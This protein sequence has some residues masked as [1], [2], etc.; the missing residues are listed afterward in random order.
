[1]RL[2]L[3]CISIFIF[4]LFATAQAKRNM[5]F[6][7]CI[8][9]TQDDGYALTGKTFTSDAS[10]ED[11]YI[12]KLDDK[13]NIKWTKS[14][15]GTNDQFGNSIIQTKSGGYAVTGATN[16]SGPTGEDVYIVD[17]DAL[18]NIKCT[19]SIGGFND[20]VGYTIYQ[21]DDGSFVVTGATTPLGEEDENIYVVK[22]DSACKVKS[23]KVIP[24]LK[25]SH[26]SSIIPTSDGGYAIGGYKEAPPTEHQA[27]DHF[28]FS[29]V[30][31]DSTGNVQW[32]KT[33]GGCRKQITLFHGANQ[34]R[35]LCGNRNNR[36]RICR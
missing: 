30:K 24:G 14:A 10:G 22:I 5:G 15:G 16:S 6:S 13:G 27:V 26:G 25:Y 20:E 18:G 31:L 19:Q 12:V 36:F 2:F 28:D 3:L 34:R 35:G 17:V 21:T 7:S 33:I 1:M 9:Q 32:N 11:I 29:I 23:K 8:I 4:S